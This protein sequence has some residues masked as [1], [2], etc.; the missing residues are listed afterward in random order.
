[1]T[2]QQAVALVI[3]N[4]VISLVITLTVVL[5]FERSRVVPTPEG[6]A[7]AQAGAPT[8]E[9]QPEVTSPEPPATPAI[10]ATYV[11]KSGDSLGSV[12]YQ[13][14][15]TLDALMA[16]NGIENANYI[17]VGQS[18]L[19][20]EGGTL[21][22]PTATPRPGATMA[23]VV[24]PASGQVPVAIEWVR[25]AGQVDQEQVR[26]INRGA[27]GV[28]LQGWVLEDED[29]HTYS[30]PNLFLWRNG[31]VSVHTAF[32]EDSVA[33]LYWGLTEAVWDRPEEK[34]RLRSASGEVVA[35]VEV[36]AANAG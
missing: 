17:V 27:E 5:V 2:R 4:A 33:D 22:E 11:V 13:F 9:T 7:L 8:S 14:G 21:P 12:A 18:L 30:F 34:I 23:P 3:C 19:I 29:G 26:L 15:V 36:G 20:P 28:A 25:G 16:A 32:G 35:E 24:T 31:T 1:M 6:S 10:K